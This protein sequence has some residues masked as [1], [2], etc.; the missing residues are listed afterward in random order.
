[1]RDNTGEQE[2]DGDEDQEDG[3]SD[4]DAHVILLSKALGPF[5]Y[6]WSL[7]MTYV[8]YDIYICGI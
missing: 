8:I 3:H 1:M 7:Y 2:E 6:I 5:I 4:H